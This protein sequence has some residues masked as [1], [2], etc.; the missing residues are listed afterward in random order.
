MIGIASLISAIMLGSFSVFIPDFNPVSFFY[1]LL[2]NESLPDYLYDGFFAMGHFSLLYS[3]IA[4]LLSPV[5]CRG[6]NIRLEFNFDRPSKEDLVF[7]P[8]LY[9][10][11]LYVTYVNGLL[12]FESAVVGIVAIT[13]PLTYR[14]IVYFV[15][16]Q[17][18]SHASSCYYSLYVFIVSIT[19]AIPITVIYIYV[20]HFVITLF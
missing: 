12:S 11:Y 1:Q 6:V 19:L 5:A 20:S 10:V 14:F 7:I 16:Y 8:L 2:F 18:S 17:L 15:D 3:F 4:L 13:L 9:I